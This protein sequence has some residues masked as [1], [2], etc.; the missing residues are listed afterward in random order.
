MGG[1]SRIR[2]HMDIPGGEGRHVDRAVVTGQSGLVALADGDG[3]LSAAFATATATAEDG[4]HEAHYPTG[5][6]PQE[7]PHGSPSTLGLVTDAITGKERI[8]KRVCVQRQILGK[9]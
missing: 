7:L 3:G 8:N 4:L 6:L 2:T 1:K 5:Q 9:P